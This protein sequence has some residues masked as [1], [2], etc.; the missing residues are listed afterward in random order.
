MC[1]LVRSTVIVFLFSSLLLSC[2]GTKYVPKEC[3]QYVGQKISKIPY[4]L[5]RAFF[6]PQDEVKMLLLG[7]IYAERS[8]IKVAAF[9]LTD[10]HIAQ[11]LVM[12][13]QRG[14][15]V[16]IV[17]DDSCLNVKS[18]KITKLRAAGIP[19]Q[20]YAKPYSLMHNKY[21]IFQSCFGRSLV[22]T[23]SANATQSGT[24]RNIENI[25]IL[26]DKTIVA[27]YGNNFDAI[28]KLTKKQRPSH[29]NRSYN[30]AFIKI[31]N[32]LLEILCGT[33]I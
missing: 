5:A 29:K 12:A 18:Q 10:E 14:V 16:E 24:T 3:I 6:V 2:A 33:Y 17:V 19:V 32:R 8:S 30:H 21:F 25:C 23:G 22:W 20:V 13:R 7:L 9:C 27:Q 28:K 15:A 1:C 11:A 31:F 26:E 4:P